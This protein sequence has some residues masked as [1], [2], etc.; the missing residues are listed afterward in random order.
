MLQIRLQLPRRSGLGF[1]VSRDRFSERYQIL[2]AIK[3]VKRK[4]TL[5]GEAKTS[6]NGT[7]RRGNAAEICDAVETLYPWHR[8]KDPVSWM[9]V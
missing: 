5:G 1:G 4:F 2:A 8:P 3:V 6:P 9:N 7:R